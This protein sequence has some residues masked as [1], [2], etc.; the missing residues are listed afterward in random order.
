[1]IRLFTYFCVLALFV[2]AGC[3][4]EPR[5]V[6]EPNDVDETYT[7]L[8]A[9]DDAGLSTFS[10]LVAEADLT[11]T[12]AGAG[13]YTVFAPSDEAFGA[14]DA[15][16]VETLRQPENRG[17]LQSV[18]T[19]HVISG[20]FMSGDLSGEQ[21]VET[22]NGESLTITA[23]DEGVTL[24]DALGN[25]ATV[26]SAD[27]DADNGVVH[28]IDA[29]M[30]PAAPADILGDEAVPADDPAGEDVQDGDDA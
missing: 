15:Q 17:A 19:Y 8:D 2:V 16:T 20:T 30:L 6:D 28:V 10:V 5:P 21:T 18:L 7:V 11:E 22:V 13:P 3:A 1:M 26:I 24:T 12:L 23:T 27:L 25:T 4:D 29:V 9:A 14:L